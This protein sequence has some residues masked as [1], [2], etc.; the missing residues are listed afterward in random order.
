MNCVTKAILCVSLLLVEYVNFSKSLGQRACPSNFFFSLEKPGFIQ[1]D[2]S[3]QSNGTDVTM[4]IEM[5]VE[6]TSDF[7]ADIHLLSTDIIDITEDVILLYKITMPVFKKHSPQIT[8]I[9]VNEE[10]ICWS[11]VTSYDGLGMLTLRYD[12]RTNETVKTIL[13]HDV[14]PLAPL[15]VDES[16]IH[17]NK[18]Y[19]VFNIQESPKPPQKKFMKVINKINFKPK[20]PNQSSMKYPIFVGSDVLNSE[21]QSFYPTFAVRRHSELSIGDSFQGPKRSLPYGDVCGKPVVTNQLIVGGSEVPNGAYPWLSALF[22]VQTSGLSYICSGSLFSHKHVV[23]AAHCVKKNSKLLKNQDLLVILGK[24]N[25]ARWVP[26][27]GE[28]IM[29]VESIYVHQDY[30]SS[31]SDADIAVILLRES[32]DFTIFVRPICLWIGSNKLHEIVDRQGIVAGWGR[33]ETGSISSEPK[34]TW[35]PIVDQET[36]IR[37]AHQFQFITSNRTFCAGMRD[38]SGPCNG[39]SGSGFVMKRD[40]VFTLRGIVSMSI[41]DTKRR[42]CDLSNYIVFTDASKFIDWLLSFI[43]N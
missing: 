21:Y 3:V 35:M 28:R 10:E 19:G 9:I 29:E 24:T 26:S 15:D 4:L 1:G 13:P 41:S 40:G 27:E 30:I 16:E 11:N 14:V 31:N 33:T 37:S 34:Q 12:S 38:G 36:C 17:N 25:L 18:L 7:Q 23:T 43:T 2:I 42:S 20:L 5:L 32:V 6:N 22:K 39:D 8:T